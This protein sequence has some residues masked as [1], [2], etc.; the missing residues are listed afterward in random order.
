[1][2]ISHPLSDEF[3][4]GTHG[5]LGLG[6]ALMLS[7]DRTPPSSPLSCCSPVHG[8]E[9][10]LQHQVSRMDTLAGI[11]IKYGV[12]GSLLGSSCQFSR[13][14]QQPSYYIP[15]LVGHLIFCDVQMQ[16]RKR[17]SSSNDSS[18]LETSVSRF[19]EARAL[20][21]GSSIPRRPNAGLLL[22][23]VKQEAADY[24][25]IDGLNGPK[26]FGSAKRRSL[27]GGSG[28]QTETE[29]KEKKLR[30]EDALNATKAAVEEGIV[31]GGGC[32][33]VR[34]ASKVDAINQTLENDEQRV[35]A[36][37][38]SRYGYNAATGKYEDLMAAGIIDPT[39]VVRCCLEHA[40]SV[41]KTFI[42]SD[43]VVVD[44]RVPK[45]TPVVNPMC[46]SGY[47]F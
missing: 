33:L 39:K 11:A 26:L 32:T 18:M 24:S 9:G 12:E 20:H 46:G 13:M 25:D 41:A 27:D 31:A 35:L 6:G 15:C 37:D 21:D 5:G 42:T 36:I 45:C 34:L 47:G 2:G 7:P 16:W 28:A 29:L 44:I 4:G 8:Q 19:S 22:E 30:V 38:N 40:A 1:M 10:F 23:D 3:Y 43:A 17:L 14:A